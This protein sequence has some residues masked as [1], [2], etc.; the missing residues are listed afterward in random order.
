MSVLKWWKSDCIILIFASRGYFR[1]IQ[2]ILKKNIMQTNIVKPSIYIID[3][4][5]YIG[6]ISSILRNTQSNTFSYFKFNWYMCDLSGCKCVNSKSNQILI[7]KLKILE[8]FIDV[9]LG[10]VLIKK[11]HMSRLKICLSPICHQ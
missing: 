8:K 2:L 9:H 3:L 5:I 10:R 6:L 4:T 1:K 11:Y 7:R